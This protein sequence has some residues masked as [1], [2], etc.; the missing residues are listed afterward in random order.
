MG[1]W[2]WQGKGGARCGVPVP[3]GCGVWGL[4]WGVGFGVW[5]VG[6]VGFA[7]PVPVPAVSAG[8]RSGDLQMRGAPGFGV[9]GVR[10]GVVGDGGVCGTQGGFILWVRTGVCDAPKGS[11]LGSVM[12]QNK[13]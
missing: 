6:C 8:S 5:G 9:L 1:V 3:I 2:G 12:P 13:V 4:L 10:L 7:V 11:R